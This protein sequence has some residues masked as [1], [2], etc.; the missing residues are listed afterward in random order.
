MS[1]EVW[2]VVSNSLCHTD[3]LIHKEINLTVLNIINAVTSTS[4]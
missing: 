2:S 1:E 3:V 4:S